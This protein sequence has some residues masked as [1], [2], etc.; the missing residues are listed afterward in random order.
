MSWALGREREEIFLIA[1]GKIGTA[2]IPWQECAGG[3]FELRS[4]ALQPPIAAEVKSD[5]GE[6]DLQ[7]CVGQAHPAHRAKMIAAFP[8]PEDF[9]DPCADRAQRAVVPFE[10]FGRKPAMAGMSAVLCKSLP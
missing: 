3:C 6:R 4:G 2:I 10:C 1:A 8:D 7:P 9:F 5:G